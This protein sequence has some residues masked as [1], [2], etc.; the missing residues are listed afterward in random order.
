MKIELTYPLTVRFSSAMED[1]LADSSIFLRFR[2][3][4]RHVIPLG[5]ELRF[6]GPIYA[7]PEATFSHGGFWGSGAFSYS[8]SNLT[9]DTELG[10]YCSVAP[11]TEIT[12]AEH[13]LDYIST[14]PFTCAQ[15]FTDLY[16]RDYGEAPDPG[17][18]EIDRGPVRVGNDVW[19][20]QRVLI[21]RGVTIGDGAVIAAGSVVVKDVPPFAVVGG[22]PARV[23]RYRFP[24]ALIERIQRVAWWQYHVADFA[25]LDVTNPE[26][27]VDGVEERVAAGTIAPFTPPWLNLP[28]MFSMLSPEFAPANA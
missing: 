18:F 23:L 21:R 14:H 24:D 12:G 4:T 27:F 8:L 16:M 5:T 7:E 1:F 20:A 19:I 26:R 3:D 22:V 28:L 15:Q 25:G 10:R 17:P 11:G 2:R 6:T 13:P 9:Q